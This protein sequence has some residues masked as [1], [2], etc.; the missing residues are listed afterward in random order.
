MDLVDVNEVSKWKCVGGAWTQSTKTTQRHAGV[1]VATF[2]RCGIDGDVW[3]FEG[4]GLGRDWDDWYFNAVEA[5]LGKMQ[6]KRYLV[7][8]LGFN[9]GGWSKEDLLQQVKRFKSM[10]A[11][12]IF[13]IP[14]DKGRDDGISNRI[15]PACDALWEC[16]ARTTRLDYS[17]AE[18]STSH[19]GTA[20]RRDEYHF[21]SRDLVQLVE[22][23]TEH[24][25]S[26]MAPGGSC[27]VITDSSWTSHDYN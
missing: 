23:Q 11:H 12:V 16:W 8:N 7:V 27:L 22:R 21:T 9:D 5:R 13:C 25:A 2:Q 4:R 26:L 3:S 20:F 18:A 6:A 14:D 10:P 24:L 17:G 1:A 19:D 15:Q